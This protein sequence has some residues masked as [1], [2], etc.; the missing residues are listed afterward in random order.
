MEGGGGLNG[1]GG[2]IEGGGANGFRGW[3]HGSGKKNL[4]SFRYLDDLFFLP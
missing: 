3:N 2:K 4:L 1:F